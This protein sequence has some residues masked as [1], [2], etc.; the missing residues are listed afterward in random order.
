[1]GAFVIAADTLG[2]DVERTAQWTVLTLHFVSLLLE[3]SKII[4]VNK[5]NNHVIISEWSKAT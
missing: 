1:M 5:P 4:Y 3:T 2:K